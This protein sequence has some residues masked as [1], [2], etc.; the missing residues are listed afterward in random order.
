[1]DEIISGAATTAATARC[2][3]VAAATTACASERAAAA[4]TGTAGR[5]DGR[6]GAAVT[7]L[8]GRA[9]LACAARTAAGTTGTTRKTTLA[10]QAACTVRAI[11]FIAAPGAAA[12]RASHGAAAGCTTAATS[13]YADAAQSCRIGTRKE[14]DVRHTAAAGALRACW[15]RK[16]CTAVAAAVT[17]AVEA[18]KAAYGTRPDCWLACRSYVD[19]QGLPRSYCQDSLRLSAQASH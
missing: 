9:G 8:A 4:S 19:E 13:N 6:A 2:S 18:T 17:A 7:A 10:G 11:S 16:R 12:R 3:G 14:A 5:R 15:R 1:V